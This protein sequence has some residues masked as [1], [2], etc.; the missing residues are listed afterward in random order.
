MVPCRAM[1]EL[2]AERLRI[3]L[4]AAYQILEREGLTTY[5]QNHV[6]ARVPGTTSEFLIAPYGLRYDEVTPS[7]LVHVDAG[8][9]IVVSGDGPFGEQVNRAGLILHRA[10][11][12]ARRDVVCV[13][14]THT[15]AGAAVSAMR[16]GLLSVCIEAAQFHNCVGYHPFEGITVNE[17]ECV[18]I[19][20]SLGGHDA[21]ILRNHGLLTVGTSV[22]EAVVRMLFLDRAC[23]VQVSL[24]QSGQPIDV[25]PQEIAAGIAHQVREFV[26][27]GSV[28]DLTFAALQRRLPVARYDK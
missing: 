19:A 13:V 8:G 17:D 18:R 9:R 1:S 7:S 26:P 15:V 22:A 11:H 16:C 20:E 6:T 21:L 3:E 28:M 14:H 10:V 25:I 27:G 5:I 2:S 23:R 24:L 12:E 4:A